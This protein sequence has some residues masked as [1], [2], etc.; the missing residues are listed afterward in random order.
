MKFEFVKAMLLRSQHEAVLLIP[1]LLF[2]SIR[3][4][5]PVFHF[6]SYM[7]FLHAVLLG[8]KSVSGSVDSFGTGEFTMVTICHGVRSIVGRIC[9]VDPG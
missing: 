1:R 4:G 2:L 9:G 8:S 7:L 3:Q 6:N 5:K